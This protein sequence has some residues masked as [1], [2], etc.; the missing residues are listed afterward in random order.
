M[1]RL[2]QCFWI[3]ISVATSAVSAYSQITYFEQDFN[4]SGPYV[5]PN[6]GPGQFTNIIEN[7]PATSFIKFQNG[8]ME[9]I[10]TQNG[11]GGSVSAVRSVPFSPNPE[12]L[13]IQITLTVKN[14]TEAGNPAAYFYIG[15]NFFSSQFP[16]NSALFSRPSIKFDAS[17]FVIRDVNTNSNSGTFPLNTPVTLTWVQNNSHSS[18][19]YKMPESASV[20]NNAIGAQRYDLWVNN[21]QIV[22]EGISYPSYSISKLSNMQIRFLEGVGTISIDNIRIRDIDGVLPVRFKNFNAK[23]VEKDAELFWEAEQPRDS[24]SFIVQRSQDN[25]HFEAVGEVSTIVD[26][27]AGYRFIDRDIPLGTTYYRV[28]ELANNGEEVAQSIVRD[29]VRNGV[30]KSFGIW[31]NPSDGSVIHF[32]NLPESAKDVKLLNIQGLE[33]K[34]SAKRMDKS[35]MDVMPEIHLFP[36]LYLI[37]YMDEGKRKSLKVL[38]GRP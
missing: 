35:R 22:D 1:N 31:P 5:N 34:M 14:V 32:F 36:G 28:V 30:E 16:S 11:N 9:M 37:T 21:V 10:R 24:M 3:L 19:V 27:I 18:T 33:I 17:G 29:I 4:G 38:V 2:L 23:L 26:P 20:A 12:T 7:M 13:Y 6:P 15:E 25:I 8:A